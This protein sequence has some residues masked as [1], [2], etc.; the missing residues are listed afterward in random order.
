MIEI[1]HNEYGEPSGLLLR[2]EHLWALHRQLKRIGA[3]N[4]ARHRVVLKQVATATESILFEP[5]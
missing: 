1:L 5:E 3:P 2:G 4:L